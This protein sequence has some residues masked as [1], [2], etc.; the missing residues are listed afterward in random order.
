MSGAS[1]PQSDP[2]QQGI[3]LHELSEAF[4]R[5]IGT[6][7]GP[8]VPAG[9]EEPA[10][11]SAQDAPAS[12][13]ERSAPESPTPSPPE[14]DQGADDADPC[15][16]GPRSILE[17]ML[18]VGNRQ[19]EPLAAQ[20][21]ADLMRGIQPADIQDLVDELNARYR[22]AGSP[23][24]IISQGAGYRMVLRPQ[25]N[26]IRNR[27]YG[28]VREVRLSQAAIDVLAIVAYR[29]PLTAD[30]VSRVR[31]KPCNHVLVQ[32]VRRQLLRIERTSDKPRKTLYC[33]TPRFLALFGLESLGDLPQSEE[34]DKR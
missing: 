29:Q 14:W 22:S 10:T 32:L 31:G 33:T 23:Y 1:E 26:P 4:A 24:E 34:V 27:F 30:D 7:A 11:S 6:P 18:F 8:P 25:F 15:Q 16:I 12:E 9:P 21:A 5:A 3:S 20:Q 19:S 17:A 2:L 13:G 28:R